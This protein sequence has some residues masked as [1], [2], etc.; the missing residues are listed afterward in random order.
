[1]RSCGSIAVDTAGAALV[2]ALLVTFILALATS[3][4]ACDGFSDDEPAPTA[5]G[6]P[7]AP[8]TP[9]PLPQTPPPPIAPPDPPLPE[10]PA[11]PVEPGAPAASPPTDEPTI[12]ASEEAPVPVA[13]TTPLLYDTYDLSGAVSEPGHY[14]FLAHPNVPSSVVTTY[15]GL[16]DGTTI[17]LLIHTHDAHGIS[18][19]VLYAAVAPGDLVEWRQADDCFVRYQ[20]T[21][22]KPDPA[23]TVPQKLLGRGLD[24][25]RLRRLHGRDQRR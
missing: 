8:A 6:E 15:E 13:E 16:R 17:A 4:A 3:L 5:P 24:D 11:E 14:A 9:A 2:P 7:P 25:L 23:G 21:E 20:V 19:A 10:P 1:M 12:T 22:V 18:Q